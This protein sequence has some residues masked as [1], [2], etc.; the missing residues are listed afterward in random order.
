MPQPL[1][2][3]E[4]DPVPIV[5]EAAAV[6]GLVWMGAGNVAPPRFNPQTVQIKVKVKVKVNFILEQAMKA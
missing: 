5:Q 6:P 1:Y 3:W 4:R 2:P